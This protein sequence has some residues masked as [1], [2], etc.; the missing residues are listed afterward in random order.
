MEKRRFYVAIPKGLFQMVLPI[1]ILVFVIPFTIMLF[2]HSLNPIVLLFFFILDTPL[3]FS[4]F[5]TKNYRIA[6]EDNH[7]TVRRALGRR[8]SFEIS[9]IEKVIYR[10]NH[11]QMGITEKYT[12]YAEKHRFSVE[13]LMIGYA[14]MKIYIQTYVPKNKIITKEKTFQNQKNNP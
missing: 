9:D 4:A 1:C 5:W 2:Q 6:I 10:I 13:S 11:T 8:F 7:I 12:I 3:I 14:P